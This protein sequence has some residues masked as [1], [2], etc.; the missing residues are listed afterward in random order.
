MERYFSAVDKV[1]RAHF[2]FSLWDNGGDCDL[3]LAAS[4]GYF[5]A[6]KRH[7]LAVFVVFTLA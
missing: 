7:D 6:V 4:D 2:C 5:S 1:R 3:T